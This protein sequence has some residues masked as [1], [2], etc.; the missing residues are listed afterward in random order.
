MRKKWERVR[1]RA[2]EIE[3]ASTSMIDRQYYDDVRW[4]ARVLHFRP[5]QPDNPPDL[6]GEQDLRW[7]Y[8]GGAANPPIEDSIQLEEEPQ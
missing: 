8:S 1:E 3:S 6:H 5:L 2:T 7:D 4:L